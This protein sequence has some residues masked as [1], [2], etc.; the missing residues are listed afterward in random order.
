MAK[1]AVLLADGFVYERSEILK[2]LT[3]KETAPCTNE[4]LR[5][6]TVLKLEPLRIAVH[7][8]LQTGRNPRASRA[9]LERELL[10][11]EMA[12]DGNNDVSRILDRSILLE[13]CINASL[14]EITEWQ[15]VVNQAR[16]TVT[17]LRH[18]SC[19]IATVQ[20]QAAVRTFGA[21]STL[22]ELRRQRE[23]AMRLH[24]AVQTY[25]ARKCVMQLQLHHASVNA[26]LRMQAVARSHLAKREVNSLV[27]QR[28]CQ[29][30]CELRRACE[31]GDHKLVT[32]CVQKGADVN[33]VS[34]DGNSL[35]YLA[36]CEGHLEVVRSLFE[37][38]ADQ[39]HEVCVAMVSQNWRVIQHMSKEMQSD[40]ELCM[41]AVAQDWR[42]WT[43]AS[44]VTRYEHGV[45]QATIGHPSFSLRD[46]PE[47]MKNDRVLCTAVVTQDGETLQ[48]ASEEMKGSGTTFLM[49]CFLAW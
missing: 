12:L 42:A 22:V 15:T 24:A 16:A 37:A 49:M 14:A 45:F 47:A 44:E 41:A 8:W 7:T 5:H 4:V 9:H 27:A 32:R 21:C 11:A 34:A 26:T 29:L 28:Q 23:H 33:H 1:S 38:R 19:A 13:N 39:N 46:V 17:K 40:R 18:N 30:N 36:S 48:W 31:N 35:L 3:H 20:V 43:H 10:D 2:W 6:K 25:W